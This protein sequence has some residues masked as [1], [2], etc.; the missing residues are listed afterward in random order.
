MKKTALII[1]ALMAA[2]VSYGQGVTAKPS[3]SVT[4]DFSYTSEYVFRGIK[5]SNA[6][7]QGSVEV[8]QDDFRLGVWTSQPLNSKGEDLNEIDFYAGY[9]LKLTRDLTAD[10]IGTYYYYPEATGGITHH[11]YEIG[12][13]GIFNLEGLSPAFK[14]ASTS[15]YYY[16]DFRLKAQTV[17][18]SLGYSLALTSIG[19]SIDFSV[20][21][22][23]VG[24]HNMTPDIVSPNDTRESWN[25][26]GIGVNIPYKLAENANVHV[27]AS[28][29][30][31]DKFFKDFRPHQN[32]AVTAGVT[33]GF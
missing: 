18:A 31:N 2:G 5:N 28:L 22:G 10:F 20:F 3:Y 7:F 11:S 19:T 9:K 13:G 21:A 8:G 6:A 17:Q 23:V 33:I 14:G 25:Y 32:A 4:T 16:Y 15:L 12:V 30:Q 26:Y 29:T 1:A 27:G 24:A